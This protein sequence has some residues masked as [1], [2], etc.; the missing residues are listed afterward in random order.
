MLGAQTCAEKS[1][2]ELIAFEENK[3]YAANDTFDVQR[4]LSSS[5]YAR[6]SI[7]WLGSPGEILRNI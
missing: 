1:F 3:L 6:C 5:N 2:G 7:L 4:I